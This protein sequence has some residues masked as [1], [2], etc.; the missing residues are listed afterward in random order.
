[1]ACYV[2]HR[3]SDG[4]WRAVRLFPSPA[5]QWLWAVLGPLLMIFCFFVLFPALLSDGP[6]QGWKWRPASLAG[7]PVPMFNYNLLAGPLFEEF[8]WRGFLLPR[9][10]RLLP[11]WMAAAVVGLLWAAWHLPLFLLQNWSSASP[12]VYLVIVTGFSLVIAFRCNSS[13][14]SVLV[15]ILMHSA[16]NAS[17]RFLGEYLGSTPTR[18]YPDATWYI[19]AAILLGGLGCVVASR[20]RMT[21]SPGGL[22]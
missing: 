17:P 13:G 9:L 6:P 4:N 7:L 16:F 21:V 20:G 3:L 8:G 1:M 5:A 15:A 14:G 12:L 10:Q 22:G 19:A 18:N 2:A 11:A